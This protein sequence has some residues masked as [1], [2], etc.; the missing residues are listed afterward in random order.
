MWMS[1]GSPRETRRRCCCLFHCLGDLALDESHQ[2][3]HRSLWNFWYGGDCV[4]WQAVARSTG[5]AFLGI[6][7]RY[8]GRLTQII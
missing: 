7:L 3:G 2:I 6:H 1:T 8:M 5:R 4:R